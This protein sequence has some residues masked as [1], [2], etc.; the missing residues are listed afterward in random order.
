MHVCLCTSNLFSWSVCPLTG[1]IL[2]Q[3]CVGNHKC[4]VCFSFKF[5]Q[6]ELFFTWGQIAFVTISVG[7][8]NQLFIKV[9]IILVRTCCVHLL[10]LTLFCYIKKRPVDFTVSKA[11]FWYVLKS[12]AVPWFCTRKVQ[13]TE[14]KSRKFKQFISILFLKGCTCKVFCEIF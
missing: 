14:K 4:S 13:E 6:N 9:Q 12:N 7:M 3:S 5:K 1:L 11:V 8:K 10:Y 2:C